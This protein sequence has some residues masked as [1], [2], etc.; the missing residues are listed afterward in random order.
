MKK[1]NEEQKERWIKDTALFYFR[2]FSVNYE[3][4]FHE[5]LL[6]GGG[7]NSSLC[8][9]WYKLS[10]VFVKKRISRKA[11]ETLIVKGVIH[12]REGN[13]V[14]LLKREIDIDRHELFYSNRKG[15]ENRIADGKYLHFDHHPSNKKILQLMNFEI[16]QYVSS[17]INQEMAT[18]NLS[19]YLKTIQTEDLITVE[20]DDIRTSADRGDEPQDRDAREALIIDDWYELRIVKDFDD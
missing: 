5:T 12:R 3:K 16:K 18:I 2:I 19:E 13:V 15:A 9:A 8:A 14:K 20:Q 1:M 4:S 6:K 7:G 10:A 11:L 17:G